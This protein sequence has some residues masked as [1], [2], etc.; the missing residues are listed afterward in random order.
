MQRK[1]RTLVDGEE[2][3]EVSSSAFPIPNMESSLLTVFFLTG[4]GVDFSGTKLELFFS[5][6]EGKSLNDSLAF[7]WSR[8]SRDLL[9]FC[10]SDL[11]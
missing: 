9:S 4:A 1:V 10:K 7:A 8:D 6:D 2:R 3:T 5:D 11:N